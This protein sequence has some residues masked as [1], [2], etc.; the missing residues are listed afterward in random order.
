[1]CG[2]CPYSGRPGTEICATATPICVLVWDSVESTCSRLME[3]LCS[4]HHINL[5]KCLR[6]SIAVMKHHDQKQ[7][8]GKRVYFLH[9]PISKAVRL[10]TQAGQDP[11][12][13]S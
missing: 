3:A 7:L 1:M 13:R 9:S 8:G 4:E 10:G 6:V 2:D 11:G 12:G 5:I